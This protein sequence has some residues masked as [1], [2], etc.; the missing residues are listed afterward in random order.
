M[1]S[2]HRPRRPRRRVGEIIVDVIKW[3][4]V[5][6]ST[7]LGIAEQCTGWMGAILEILRYFC[8]VG[9]MCVSEHKRKSAPAQV[10]QASPAKLKLRL[11]LLIKLGAFLDEGKHTLG[12]FRTQLRSV[13]TG[14]V[15]SVGPPYDTPYGTWS[16]EL[17]PRAELVSPNKRKTGNL[18]SSELSSRDRSSLWISSWAHHMNHSPAAAA[19]QTTDQVGLQ[20]CETNQISGLLRVHSPTVTRVTVEKRES[21]TDEISGT[22]TT[23]K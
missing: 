17:P 10:T 6:R 22:S 7:V 4:R 19:E 15:V 5:R 3:C 1:G 11:E 20:L 12:Q 9:R 18:A 13:Q 8:I 23:G 21:S 16:P 2:A 14:P